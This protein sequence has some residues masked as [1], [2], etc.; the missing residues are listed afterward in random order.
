M[1]NDNYT[2]KFVT[3]FTNRG[4]EMLFA[5]K[6]EGEYPISGDMIAR[7]KKAGK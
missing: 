4:L 2:T 3:T 5:N 6:C 7:I 1:T